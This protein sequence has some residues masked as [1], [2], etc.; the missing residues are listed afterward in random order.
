MR[1]ITCCIYVVIRQKVQYK[2]L[3]EEFLK[4]MC[5]TNH[6]LEAFHFT[7]KSIKN[8][9]PY[10]VFWAGELKGVLHVFEPFFH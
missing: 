1:T 5:V 2:F 7:I 10:G 3:I 8:Y 9:V 4:K 6:T